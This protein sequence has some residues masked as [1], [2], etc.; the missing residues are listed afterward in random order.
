MPLPLSFAAAR[1]KKGRE[2][3]KGGS[4]AASLP[5]ITEGKKKPKRGGDAFLFL[6]LTKGRKKGKDHCVELSSPTN[7]FVAAEGG[8]R[9]KTRPS[10]KRESK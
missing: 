2:T 6:A 5:A 9:A 3:K 7:S 4:G 8:G 1:E 10:R